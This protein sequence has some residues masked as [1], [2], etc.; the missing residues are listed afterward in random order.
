MIKN[1]YKHRHEF[2]IDIPSS[3]GVL[4]IDDCVSYKKEGI[5]HRGYIYCFR[6][7]GY[8]WFAWLYT[9][10]ETMQTVDCIPVEQLKKVKNYAQKYAINKF[11]N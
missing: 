10:V 4:Q 3:I 11:E 6:Q 9:D 5:Q 7:F 2:G 1:P 8:T